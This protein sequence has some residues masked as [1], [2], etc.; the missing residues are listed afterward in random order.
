MVA[1]SPFFLWSIAEAWDRL[2]HVPIVGFG[3]LV[4]AGLMIAAIIIAIA[5][6]L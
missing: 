4:V 5:N 3:I 1:E 6:A 2:I